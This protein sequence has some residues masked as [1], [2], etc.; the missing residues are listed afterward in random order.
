M[1]VAIKIMKSGAYCY[2]LFADV[3]EITFIRALVLVFRETRESK[4]CCWSIYLLADVN[5][6]TL[7]RAPVLVYW[8]AREVN[9]V[10]D[11]LTK[12]FGDRISCRW[13]AGDCQ[14]WLMSN[15]YKTYVLC[16][17]TKKSVAVYRL[18]CFLILSKDINQFAP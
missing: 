4:C 11:V 12:W 15:D 14:S 1:I 16:K 13:Q 10:V 7:I 2:L 5:E 6:I 9:A 17:K 8:E 18:D 3:N